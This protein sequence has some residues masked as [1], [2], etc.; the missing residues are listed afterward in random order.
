M[1]TG[2]SRAAVLV[3]PPG[4]TDLPTAN[5]NVAAMPPTAP[6]PNVAYATSPA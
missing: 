2:P 4:M 3:A 5:P 1:T 6:I